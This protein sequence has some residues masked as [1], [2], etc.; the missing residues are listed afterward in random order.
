MTAVPADTKPRLKNLSEI[1]SEIVNAALVVVLLISLP[2]AAVLLVRLLDTGWQEVMTLQFGLIA[3]LVVVALLRHR[4]DFHL[5]SSVFLGA[6]YLAGFASL[7]SFGLPGFGVE[8][9]ILASILTAMLWGGR[10]G[11]AG[12]IT[13]SL[14]VGLIGFLMLSDALAPKLSAEEY[15]G[16]NSSWVIAVAAFLLL[17]GLTAM[18][19]RHIEKTLQRNATELARGHDALRQEM[20][21]RER[22]Q[23]GAVES[24]ERLR[25]VFETVVDSIIVINEEGRIEEF[26]P[27]AERI[28]GYHRDEVV[29]QNVAMLMPE[30]DRGAHDG[31]LRNY[32][33]GGEAKVIGVG[34]EAVGQRKDGS[35]FPI[36]LAVGVAEIGGHRLFTGTVTDISARKEAEDALR[37]SERALT[38]KTEILGAVLGSMNQGIVAYDSDLK[39]VASNQRFRDIRDVPEDLTGEGTPFEDLMRFDVER[40][41]F[42]PGDPEGQ[43]YEKV[44]LARRFEEHHFERT[45][46]NGRVI[47]VEGGPLPGGGFVSTFTDITA[48]KH[49]EEA[50]RDSEARMSAILDASTIGASIFTTEGGRLYTNARMSE[51]SGRSKA[52][53]MKHDSAS[54]LA[55]PSD[56]DRIREIYAEKGRVDDFEAEFLRADGS[57]YWVLVTMTPV[58]F[59][60]EA[61]RLV[62]TYD[63]TERKAAE[64][65]ESD[66]R[67]TAQLLHDI[68]EAAQKTDS[69]EA[70]YQVCLDEVGEHMGWPVGHIYLQP[71]EM[72]DKVVPS[73][74][75]HLSESRRFAAFRQ[76]TGETS[77]ARGE[78]LPGRVLESGKPA[79]ITDVTRDTNFPRASF[80][81]DC[82]LKAGFAFPVTSERGVIAVLEFF[83][84]E[85]IEPDERTRRILASVGEQLGGIILRKRAEAAAAETR[86]MV[87]SLVDNLPQFVSMKDTEGRFILVNKVYEQ[88]SDQKRE[89]VLG[90]TVYDIFPE[91][92]AAFFDL[93]DKEAIERGGAMETEYSLAFNDGVHR[94]FINTKFAVAAADGRLL[95]LANVNHDISSIK[96]TEDALAEKQA[97]LHLAL[98]NMPGG[99]FMVDKDLRFLLANAQYSELFD[100]PKGLLAEGRDLNGMVR[101]QAERGDY[102][103]DAR[104]DEL[105]KEVRD[106]FTSGESHIYERRLASGRV[107]EVHVAP[108]PT[109][110]AVAADITER[111]LA[112]QELAAKEA[113]LRIA[114][115]HMPGGIKVVDSDLNYLLFNS[116]YSELYDF[117][118]GVLQQGGP[119]RDELR[120]QAERGDLGPGDKEAAVERVIDFYRQ[121]EGGS[122]ER[123]LPDGRVLETSMAPTPDGHYVTILTDITERKRAQ[124]D[125][126]QSEQRFKT[127]L[128]NM[129]AAVFLRD[130]DGRFSLVNRG[131]KEIYQVADK[132]VDGKTV[133]DLLPAAEADTY[134]DEDRKVLETGETLEFETSLSR[135]E[136]PRTLRTVKFPIRDLAG[137]VE[138]V[139]GIEIDI[140]EQKRAA[141]ELAEKEEQLRLA[142]ENMSDGIFLLD[143]SLRY[144]LFNQRY[145]DL[146]K[147]PHDL[148][149]VGKPIRDVLFNAAENGFY[150]P[151]DPDELAEQRLATYQ[152]SKYVEAEIKTPDNRIVSLRKTALAEGGVVA[153]LTDVTDRKR[154][155]EEVAEQKKLLDTV[156][157]NMDSGVMMYDAD[158]NLMKFNE[159][160]RQAFQFPSDFLKPGL[161]FEKSCI[162][163]PS[164]AGSS[165]TRSRNESR[166][167]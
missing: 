46:P 7:V 162:T 71:E 156:I 123:S 128:D 63:I 130:R 158:L 111:K 103:A 21:A 95:G 9:L 132:D 48:R 31:Y 79:W 164:A 38:E 96:K 100:F 60:G 126:Q 82:G 87:Q 20:L 144:C 17:T 86:E 167:P 16:A 67:R 83:A 1:R 114:L 116:K 161:S 5:K 49:A 84:T 56:R 143:S 113:Q 33:E 64:A 12:L 139:G 91:E 62:W 80:A 15:A 165:P 50:L 69:L 8:L 93:A 153:V 74:T 39:L 58:D 101:F 42:G 136:A 75:W 148:I 55:D 28:F 154:A 85:A 127:V 122:Y 92:Q 108:T 112:E 57:T 134:A 73:G 140:T 107:L 52:E 145:L 98:D 147:I 76:A 11:I 150:G 30:P 89:D 99:M 45:R 25:A 129:P 37:E 131:Y 133:H 78:G 59:G 54:N 44:N 124:E 51:M 26:S 141:A 40:G 97:Q 104:I 23:K 72:P 142:M 149:N 47:E 102:G 119:M 118:D 19:L 159:Q 34:R 160:A 68:A 70:V 29:G 137:A 4:I 135:G 163:S 35:T 18:C 109:G 61:A 2:M 66:R 6:F 10:V 110:G 43:L 120:Y 138:A 90:K 77:F 115:D 121:R 125:L 41:E 53:L 155:E 65:E 94:D 22:L 146:V 36:D 14:A 117:P 166:N 152:T 13:A 24:A 106:R 157:E 81:E 88:W 32:L 151:G 105:A 27:S 3:L